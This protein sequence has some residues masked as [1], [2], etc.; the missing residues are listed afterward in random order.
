VVSSLFRRR[1][2]GL[3]QEVRVSQHPRQW[4]PRQ[5][6]PG[7]SVGIVTSDGFSAEG[8]NYRD[9]L[10]NLFAG[11]FTAIELDSNSQTFSILFGAYLSSYSRHCAS[12]LPP[13]KV[14]MTNQE[15]ASE[16]VT[17]NGFGVVVDRT[18][19]EYVAV[20]TGLFADPVLYDAKVS[21]DDR[22]AA[23]PLHGSGGL[24]QMV[25]F[26]EAI[27]RDMNTLVKMNGCGPGLKRFQENLRL[28]Q[29][30]ADGPWCRQRTLCCYP[31]RHFSWA[32]S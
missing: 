9:L 17:R 11:K 29:P 7:S 22:L 14:E 16:R 21:V 15:C 20:G 13:K 26:K 6:T 19:V 31:R 30:A 3:L 8:L 18:C 2:L 24:L 28:A 27:Y 32:I 1:P 23:D 5:Q 10:T 4:D 12:Y 25:A